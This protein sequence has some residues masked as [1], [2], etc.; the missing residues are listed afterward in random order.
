MRTGIAAVLLSLAPPGAFGGDGD[1]P[2]KFDTL[3][4][5]DARFCMERS[6]AIRAADI[7]AR[8]GE[9]AAAEYV[10]GK[11]CYRTNRAKP[12]VLMYTEKVHEVPR[13][14]AKKLYVYKAVHFEMTW[15][16]LLPEDIF[17]ITERGHSSKKEA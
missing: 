16:V 15:G 5:A 1:Q 2:L 11:K 9:Q 6:E 7:I 8:E 17:V 4:R 13:P 10:K 3:Y 14:G 12:L